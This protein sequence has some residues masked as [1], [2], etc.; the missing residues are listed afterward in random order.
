MVPSV[1]EENLLK[2]SAQ[3]AGTPLASDDLVSTAVV[4]LVLSTEYGMVVALAPK[5]LFLLNSRGCYVAQKPAVTADLFLTLV[6]PTHE[7]GLIAPSSA[8]TTVLLP[9][10]TTPAPERDHVSQTTAATN[11]VVV[12]PRSPTPVGESRPSA[13]PENSLC[14]ASTRGRSSTRDR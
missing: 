3:T 13:L 12:P 14:A 8:V 11:A 10:L 4:A 2:V 9:G 5:A 6:A 7:R 1:P